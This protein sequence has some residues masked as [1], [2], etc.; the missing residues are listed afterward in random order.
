MP[1]K[2]WFLTSKNM[3]LINN[4]KYSLEAH[5]VLKYKF[6]WLGFS[7]TKRK[8]F[9]LLRKHYFKVLWTAFFNLLSSK[10]RKINFWDTV[11]INK[12]V[13][14]IAKYFRMVFSEIPIKKGF[15][16]N[17]ISS[18]FKA[19]NTMICIVISFSPGGRPPSS[20]G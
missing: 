20:G 12:M 18:A 13:F 1:L 11:L 7:Q 5:R 8:L 4:Y 2:Q 6:G 16:L 19:H 10:S 3:Q 17:F 15:W 14:F 9:C